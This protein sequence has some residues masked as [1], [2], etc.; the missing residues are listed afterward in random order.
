MQTDPSLDPLSPDAPIVA[1]MSVSSNPL[2][3]TATPEEVQALVKRL[4][5]LVQSPQA[6]SAKL[7]SEKPKAK[8]SVAAQRKAKLD[9]L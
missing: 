2:L 6:L 4:R 8:N 5:T 7:D 1:L 3:A 9:L